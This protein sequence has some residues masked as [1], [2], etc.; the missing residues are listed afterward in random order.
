[1]LHAWQVSD[2][3]LQVNCN[4]GEMNQVFLNLLLNSIHAMEQSTKEEAGRIT[5]ETRATEDKVLV[6]VADSG[7]GIAPE[8]REHIFEPF[9]TTKS[10]GE[11]MGQGLAICYDIVVNKH[12]G[13]IDVGGTP[14]EGAVFTVHLTAGQLAEES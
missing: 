4:I 9:F 10:V 8:I 12:C 3:W 11:G 13:S 7:D 2:N 5:L 14:G 6:N 1:M